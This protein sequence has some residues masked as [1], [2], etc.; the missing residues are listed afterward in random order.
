MKLDLTR[1]VLLAAL[2]ALVLGACGGPPR[3]TPEM[4]SY[5]MSRRDSY[6][7]TVRS[8]SPEL[9]A[10]AAS[11]YKKAEVAHEDDEPEQAMHFTRIASFKWRTALAKAKAQDAASAAQDYENRITVAEEKVKEAQRRKQD[12]IL[13]V[14]AARKNSTNER[15]Q[16]LNAVADKVKEANQMHADKYAPAELAKADAS[17][18]RAQETL[19]QGKLKDADKA[20]EVANIDADLLL[21]AVRPK[22]DVEERQRDRDSRLQALLVK[23]GSIPGAKGGIT[24]R[25]FVLTLRGTFGR[26]KVDV[27]PDQVGVLDRASEL[28]KEFSEFKLAVESHTDNSVRKDAALTLSQ[29]RAQAVL[30]HLAAKGVPA[31]RMSAL[32][33]G[34]T[35]PMADNRTRAGKEQ[36]MRVEIIFLR[37]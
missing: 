29:N 31:S 35:E 14:E 36:N 24:A 10:D 12:A 17:L 21:A 27:A 16:R 18:K 19:T 28:A 20:T 23:S 13:L 22:Y 2:A 33:K 1:S 6:A 3:K 26:N 34:G 32:G 5:E 7:E 4:E 15:Q 11:N 37:P 8:R 30:S 25:G 9:A